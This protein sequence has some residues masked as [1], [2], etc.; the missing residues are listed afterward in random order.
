MSIFSSFLNKWFVA[1]SG[2]ADP[3]TDLIGVVPV[4]ITTLAVPVG[5][6]VIRRLRNGDSEAWRELVGWW[7]PI[8]AVCLSLIVVIVLR[9]EEPESMLN[10]L[11]ILS[12]EEGEESPLVNSTPLPDVVA[13]DEV[14]KSAREQQV[15]RV[16]GVAKSM[17]QTDRYD[18]LK[19]L[20]PKVEEGVLC[21]E[22]VALLSM[23][24]QSR[25]DNL[26][27]DLIDYLQ[28]PDACVIPLLDF[29]HQ[30]DRPR[31]ARV[32]HEAIDDLEGR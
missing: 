2:F 26:I 20:V 27:V 11:T 19:E 23:V 32:I 13:V 31:I 17:H 9:N 18:Y 25:R 1:T 28:N 6:F 10:P 15:E 8:L 12:D 24:H 3:L 30:T 22:F 5:G 14:T 29:I 21:D 16:K 4:L 7:P